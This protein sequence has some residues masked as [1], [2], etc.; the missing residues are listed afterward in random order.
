ML[1]DAK[2][3]SAGN[4]VAAAASY[5]QLIGDVT[6]TNQ[7][8]SSFVQL[9]RK[10]C[11]DHTIEPTEILI[12]LVYYLFLEMGFGPQ[13]LSSTIKANIRTHWGYSFV[14]QIP[15]HSVDLVAEQIIQQSKQNQPTDPMPSTSKNNMDTNQHPD[16]HHFNLNLI[17]LS[18]HELQLIVRKLSNGIICITFCFD[19]GLETKSIVLPVSEYIAFNSDNCN[20]EHIQQNPGKYFIN[21]QHLSSLIKKELIIPIRNI[22]MDR[23][24]FP[25][26]AL[27]G[28][29][30]ESLWSLFKLLKNDLNTLQ[31]I[32]QSCVYLRYMVTEFMEEFNIR[33]R[34]RRP[35]RI[36]HD[37]DHRLNR[38]RRFHLQMAFPDGLFYSR[39]SFH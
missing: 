14:A 18:D 2:R 3:P 7:L 35:T 8:P 29:P 25:N 1:I 39:R 12:G 17:N 31:R 19:Q 11:C 32:S 26:A 36:V 10:L 37:N 27:N 38:Y 33:I 4:D 34:T 15:E 24:S 30:K 23:N 22:L 9:L 6:K 16:Q 13:I 20:I 28:L 21:T 5:Y